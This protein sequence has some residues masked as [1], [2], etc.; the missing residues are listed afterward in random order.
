MDECMA[1][2]HQGIADFEAA[3]AFDSLQRNEFHC[4]IIA[5]FQQAVEKMIKSI[6]AALRDAGILAIQIGYGHQVSP[7]MKTMLQLPHAKKD[8]TVQRRLCILLDSPTRDGIRDLERLIPRRP[9][10]GQEPN[11]N[12]EYPFPTAATWSYPAS[13]GV[14]RREEVERYRS[15]AKRVRTQVPAIV[16]I[17]R[18]GAR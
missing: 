1:W 13:K 9:P 4:Q 3:I 2:L 15:V 10:P 17:L 11:R 5:K 18:R 8:R 14:F 7:F 16:S 6:V 12:T